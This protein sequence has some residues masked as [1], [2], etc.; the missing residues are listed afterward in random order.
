[1]SPP[2]RPGYFSGLDDPRQRAKVLYPLPEIMLL[3]LWPTLSGTGN[4]VKARV[5]GLNKIRFLQ[6][7]LPF[8]RGIPAHD[9]RYGVMNALD[10][11]L[12]AAAFA[13]LG[14]MAF[15]A[16]GR[17]PARGRTRHRRHL[18]QDFAARAWQRFGRRAP[19]AYGFG[20]G[21]ASEAGAGS[22]G[23]GCEI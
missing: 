15:A 23:D 20:L 16:W 18:W 17:W 21:H 5:W 4:F 1:M 19:P 2:S 3:I 11:D 22:G 10:G 14:S 6:G 9:T 7:T 12:F 8:A 13:A